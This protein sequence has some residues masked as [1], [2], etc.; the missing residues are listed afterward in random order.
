[1]NYLGNRWSPGNSNMQI[2]KLI[3]LDPIQEF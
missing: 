2:L 1:M 3:P